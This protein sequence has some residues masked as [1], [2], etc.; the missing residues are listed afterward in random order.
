MKRKRPTT[1]TFESP[2]VSLAFNLAFVK[3]SV[4]H[5]KSESLSLIRFFLFPIQINQ[6][7]KIKV[8]ASETICTFNSQCLSKAFKFVQKLGRELTFCIA[9][10]ETCTRHAARPDAPLTS[11]F[12]S[13]PVPV[14]KE[15][16][17]FLA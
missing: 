2:S 9:L 1:F 4:M 7:V 17:T 15:K 3:S 6:L 13:K 5:A 14:R 10:E 11:F 12:T 8:L 16:K